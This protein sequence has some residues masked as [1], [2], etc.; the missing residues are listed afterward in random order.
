MYLIPETQ[1]NVP[2]AQFFTSSD[3]LQIIRIPSLKYLEVF[4]SFT[5]LDL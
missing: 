1:T 2:Y 4:S 5:E 3:S